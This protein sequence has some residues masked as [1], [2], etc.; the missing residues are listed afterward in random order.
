MHINHYISKIVE[1]ECH[2]SMSAMDQ[3]GIMTSLECTVTKTKRE[4]QK[5]RN[6]KHDASFHF[7]TIKQK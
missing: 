2:V 6:A 3:G 5:Q 7:I 4:K 1:E